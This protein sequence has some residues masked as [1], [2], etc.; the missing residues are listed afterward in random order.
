M[1]FYI[2]PWNW[3]KVFIVLHAYVSVEI[4]YGLKEDLESFN[5]WKASTQYLT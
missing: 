2:F 3:I 5:S 1:T 4:Y